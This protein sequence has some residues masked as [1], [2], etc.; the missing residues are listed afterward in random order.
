MN[1]H[2]KPRLAALALALA[3]CLVS[4]PAAQAA[5]RFSD[6]ASGA[7]YYQNV[8]ELAAAGVVSGYPDGSFRPDGSVTVGEALK[9]VLLAAGYSE[10]TPAAGAHWASGYAALASSGT[11][12]L[13]SA[14]V[15]DLDAPA[16]RLLIAKLTAQALGLAPSA[17]ESPFADIASG[18]ATALY[19]KSIMVGSTDSGERLLQPTSDIKRSEISAIVWRAKYYVSNRVAKTFAFSGRN[20]EVLAGVPALSYDVSAFSTDENGVTSYSGSGVT[21]R[22]GIDVSQFQGDI[23]WAKVKAAGID[24]VILRVGGR[25]SVSGTIYDDTR[26]AQNVKGATAAGLDVGVYFFSQAITPAEA[27]AEADYTLSK[28]NG[29]SIKM[30]VVFDWEPYTPSS[31]TTRTAGL[32]GAVLTRCALAFCSRVQAAGYSPMVYT[33]KAVGY[34]GYDLRALTDLPL[35]YAEFHSDDQNVPSF[36]YDFAMWQYSDHGTVDGISG[37]VDM[38]LQFVKN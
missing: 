34:L 20:V 11:G 9:L 29:Y 19:E 25:Y 33:N 14:E 6:V 16:S 3:L 13:T 30:P 22:R 32:D 28:I 38:D 1:I 2:K 24:Y 26:F 37:K 36:R 18:W 27:Q 21:V 35:W 5:S 31:G 23:D 10:R 12:M 15:K 17:E 7:W 8:T 4:Q